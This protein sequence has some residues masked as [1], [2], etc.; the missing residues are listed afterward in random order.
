MGAPP[1]PQYATVFFG[2]FEFLILRR[3]RNN[4]LLFK[5]YLDNIIM[6]WRHHAALID[7]RDFQAFKVLLNNWYG[8]EWEI[9]ELSEQVNFMDLLISI[10]NGCIEATLYEKPLP[11]YQFIPPHS[12]HPPSIVTGIIFGQLHHI[13]HLCTET[14][15]KKTLIAK[16]YRRLLLHGYK[17]NIIF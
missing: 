15:N 7:G 10:E 2:I 14:T 5:Q 12:V 6:L 17:Q 4:L 3:F 11:M 1:A 9:D 16:F 13:N 8:L